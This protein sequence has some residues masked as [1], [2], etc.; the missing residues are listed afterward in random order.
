MSDPT[1][2]PF[3]ND[4]FWKVARHFHPAYGV[5]AFSVVSLLMCC[6]SCGMLRSCTTPKNTEISQ[7]EIDQLKKIKIATKKPAEN[8]AFPAPRKLSSFTIEE[9]V[10]SENVTIAE[11]SK[12]SDKSKSAVASYIAAKHHGDENAAASALRRASY[13]EFLDQASRGTELQRM[14]VERALLF[15]ER[16]NFKPSEPVPDSDDVT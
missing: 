11:W 1:E 2:D 8:G 4:P 9:R 5:V 6:G 15:F 10:L 16:E 14:Y 12:L 7:S 13:L 3:R